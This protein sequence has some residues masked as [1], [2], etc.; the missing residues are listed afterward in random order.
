MAGFLLQLSMQNEICFLPGQKDYFESLNKT[1]LKL[2]KVIY[3]LMG[4]LI[5]MKGKRF[6][7]I[8]AVMLVMVPFGTGLANA[9]PFFG[10]HKLPSLSEYYEDY[11]L[12]HWN[13]LSYFDI[14][15]YFCVADNDIGLVSYELYEHGYTTEDVRDMMAR[16]QPYIMQVNYRPVYPWEQPLGINLGYG[17]TPIDWH[18]IL[19]QYGYQ[20]PGYGELNNIPK[21]TPIRDQGN[22]GTCVAFASVAFLE[23]DFI[24]HKSES[25]NLDLSEQYF[26]WAC[27]EIDGMPSS[28]GTSMTAGAKVTSQKGTCPEG[29]WPYNPNP[30]GTPGQGPPPEGAGEEAKKY[31]YPNIKYL[32]SIGQVNELK[33]SLQSNHIIVCAIPVYES[34]YKSEETKRTGEITMPLKQDKLV[35]G[36]AIA[37]VGFKDTPSQEEKYPGGGYFIVRNSWGTDWAYESQYGAGY[38]TIPYAYIQE[39]WQGGWVYSP[40]EVNPM[41]LN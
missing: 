3:E 8:L 19:Q 11:V 27:K 38:G 4:I 35:G 33:S 34:W 9:Q 6:G 25:K 16:M 7:I 14:G 32:R 15:E 1:I 26:F 10:Q 2:Q 40:T 18:R 5:T 20:I 28:D 31:V 41:T 13:T 21:C 30:A 29:T 17:I 23:Y 12:Q 39:Y 22:R 36:H 24:N 37:L